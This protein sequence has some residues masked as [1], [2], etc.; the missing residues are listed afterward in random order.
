MTKSNYKVVQY[1]GDGRRFSYYMNDQDEAFKTMSNI[2]FGASSTMY[3]L[4]GGKFVA[5]RNIKKRML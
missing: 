3:K 4:K 1:T 2:S 5:V